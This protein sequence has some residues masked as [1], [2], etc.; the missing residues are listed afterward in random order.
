[1]KSTTKYK[2]D[3]PFH[4]PKTSNEARLRVAD[5][6]EAIQS[7]ENQLAVPRRKNAFGGY[8]TPREYG[9]WRRGALFAMSKRIKEKRLLEAW[10]I[11]HRAC[12]TELDYYKE[13][14]QNGIDLLNPDELLKYLTNFVMTYCRENKDTCDDHLKTVMYAAKAYLETL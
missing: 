10:L 13:M 12:V 11:K 1:M 9:D 5:L 14:E 2:P 3:D 4:E 7:I 6:I 8:M